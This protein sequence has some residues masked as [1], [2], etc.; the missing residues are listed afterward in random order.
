MTLFSARRALLAGASFFVYALFPHIA[1]A[2]PDE[3]PEVVVTATRLEEPITR[4]GGAISVIRAADI[5]KTGARSAADV[6]RQVPGL[7]IYETGG[8]GGYSNVTLRG[9]AAGQTLVLIDGVRVGDPSSAGGEFDFGAYSITDIERIEVL[10]GPQSALYGSDAMGGVV[11][12]ITR[13]GAG[14]P[15]A[16]LTLEGGGYGALHSRAAFSGGTETLSY[17]FGIDGFRTDGFS[18]Y[19][20]RI[21]RIE[22]A[23]RAAGLPPLESDGA[24]KGGVTGRVTW[25]PTEGVEMEIGG[26]GFNL[27][28]KLDN[29]GA[30]LSDPD[31]RLMK[32]RSRTASAY[33]RASVDTFG[34]ALRHTVTLT[35][36]R[37]DRLNRLTQACF[38]SLY[39]SYDCDAFY[40]GERAGVEYQGEARLGAL[41][42]TVFGLKA[43]RETARAQERWL[44]ASPKTTQ[45]DRGQTTQSAFLQHQILLGDRLDLTVGGRVDRV[46]GGK[47][48]TT[49]RATLAYQLKETDTKLRASVGTGAKAATLYQRYSVYG[50]P[51]L[52]PEQNTGFDVGL[53]QRLWD[54]R[55]KLSATYFEARSRDLI[56][57]NMQTSKYFNVKRALTRGVELSGDM[58]LAPDVWRLRANYTYLHAEDLKTHAWLPRRPFN[59]GFVALTYSGVR[60]LEL[61]ARLTMTGRRIDIDNQSFSRITVPAWAKLDVSANY[62]L[63]DAFAVFGRVENVTNA[64]YEEVRDYATSGRAFYAGLKATW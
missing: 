2:Q 15:K 5:E 36:S 31:D 17:A 55:V 8:V 34:G 57:F 25:R 56:D 18:R 13:K 43:E 26:S 10:R 22:N 23:R 28:D 39:N 33:A 51:N 49:G 29:P 61:E 42:T 32:A 48:F 37:T 16:S 54:G 58:A 24:Q 44:P 38:D 50:D 1:A 4:T 47:T 59:K 45:I 41:G 27:F 14:K 3:L 11:N 6:L 53:D 30:F 9:A 52:R 19:G 21:K 7:D 46:L 60:N 62:K 35:G 63:N 40:R 20:Y 64:R 12:I